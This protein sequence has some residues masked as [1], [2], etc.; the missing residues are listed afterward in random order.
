VLA[1]T[2]IGATSSLTTPVHNPYSPHI[3][4]RRTVPAARSANAQYH[5]AR[6][7][8][9]AVAM[10][11][12]VPGVTATGQPPTC[13][14]N[15]SQLTVA[16]VVPFVAVTIAALYYWTSGTPTPDG[17]ETRWQQRLDG[18]NQDDAKH[19]SAE[20]SEATLEI[21]RALIREEGTGDADGDRGQVEAEWT[22]MLAT[23]ATMRS[24]LEEGLETE[25]L[26]VKTELLAQMCANSSMDS[27]RR[28][29]PG[30]CRGWSRHWCRPRQC[31]WK[32]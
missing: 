28:T 11:S 2:A 1:C 30:Q 21:K 5:A 29:R 25:L 26:A 18:L 9:R 15:T 8:H 20:V 6:N 19:V 10:L 32:G 27:K 17:T 16:A 7:V 31:R 14:Q 23:S 3:P 12:L 13:V 22:S 4:D 24:R